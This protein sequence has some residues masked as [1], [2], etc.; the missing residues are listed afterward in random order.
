[1]SEAEIEALREALAGLTLKVTAHK[2]MLDGVKKEISALKGEDLTPG[3][4]A[5]R[6]PADEH[7][8]AVLS[9]WY[10]EVFLAAFPSSGLPVCVLGHPES[11]WELGNMMVLWQWIY[12]RPKASKEGELP[13]F[14]DPP[15]PDALTLFDRFMP[16]VISRLKLVTKNCITPSQCVLRREERSPFS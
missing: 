2:S 3:P 10:A 4:F 9:E 15:L 14:R 16:G 5:L 12:E 6:W 13:E 8:A 1:M 7:Q 11:R